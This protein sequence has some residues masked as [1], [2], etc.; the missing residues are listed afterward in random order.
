ML[1]SIV[2]CKIEDGKKKKSVVRVLRKRKRE[3]KKERKKE[4]K[5]EKKKK[6]ERKR[7]NEPQ[8]DR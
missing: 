8:A 6:R 3:R 7:N 4:K 2:I 5:R 1:L